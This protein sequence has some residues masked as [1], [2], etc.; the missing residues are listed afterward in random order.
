MAD[1]SRPK[2]C[3]E[4]IDRELKERLEQFL[5]EISGWS[6][7]QCKAFLAEHGGG[8]GSDADDL[9]C[10]VAEAIRQ[11]ASEQLLACDISWTFRLCLSWGGP[12]DFFELDW[13][14]RSRCWTSGRYI[15]QD[16]FDGAE[17]A[18]T[19]EQAE[20]LAEVFGIDPDCASRF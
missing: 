6:V 4:R 13:C 5:P 20:Q 10:A 3:A 7:R 16:W 15:L 1:R 2:S 12:A 11:M 17:R 18:I 19:T 8:S 9:R 14:P